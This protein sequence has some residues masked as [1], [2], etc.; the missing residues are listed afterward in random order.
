MLSRAD[1]LDADLWGAMV[2]NRSGVDVLLAPES[3]VEGASELRDAA[4]IVEYAR[5]SYDAIV[6]DAS[7]MYGPWNL[8]Q[9]RT[10]DEVL[11]VT[12]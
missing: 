5:Q 3:L 4:P 2:T 1:T 11:L 7:G 12:G 10:A 9:A 6:L 8:S